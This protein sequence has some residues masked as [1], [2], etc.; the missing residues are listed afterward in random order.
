MVRN[1][2]PRSGLTPIA[3]LCRPLRHRIRDAARAQILFLCLPGV[4]GFESRYRSLSTPSQAAAKGLPRLGVALAKTEPGAN[5][6]SPAQA[7]VLEFRGRS[8][9]NSQY[10]TSKILNGEARQ[11]LA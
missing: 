10:Q 11:A 7:R 3:L 9:P 6:L 2:P 4:W 8:P 5:Y 1:P